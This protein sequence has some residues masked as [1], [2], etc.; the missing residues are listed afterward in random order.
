MIRLAWLCGLILTGTCTAAD[1]KKDVPKELQPFQGAWK[2]VKVESGGKAPPGGLTEEVRFTFVGNKLTIKEG[3][4]APQE[5]TYSVDATKDPNEIDLI[6]AKKEKSLGIFQF[7]KDGRLSV[8]FVRKAGAQRPKKLEDPDTVLLVLEK[9][10][11]KADDKK[12]IAKELLPFQGAWKVV[13]LEFGGKEPPGGVPENAR[14][15]FTR[16]KLIIKEGQ[17]DPQEGTCIIDPKTEPSAFDFIS[18]KNERILG[19]YKFDKDG[20]LFINTNSAPGGTRPKK[21]D[22]AETVLFV[23]EKVK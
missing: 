9:V 22:Q 6:N 4:G 10:K 16:D 3:K 2:V 20:K 11:E 7:E 5:G 23:L 1:D 21:F 18:S 12:E 19:I 15:T 8:S 14:F 13:K 17:K